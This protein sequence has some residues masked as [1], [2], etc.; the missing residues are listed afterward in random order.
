MCSK[1]FG[2]T[3]II[4]THDHRINAIGASAGNEAEID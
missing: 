4:D 2:F 1:L 3:P